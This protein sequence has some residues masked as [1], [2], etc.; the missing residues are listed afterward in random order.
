[1]DLS[2]HHFLAVRFRQIF[3]LV[4]IGLLSNTP[5]V[6]QHVDG[7]PHYDDS[8]NTGHFHIHQDST[9]HSILDLF[10]HG[11]VGGHIRNYTMATINDGVLNDY[12]TNA[13]GG[14][15]HFE[16]ADWKGLQFGVKG[17]F[18]YN[19]LGSDLTEPDTIVGQSAKWE[20]EL[21]D[22]SRPE[23]KHD[24]D[25]L[26]ELYIKYSLGRSYV[27]AG[28]ID[29]NRGPLFLRR[30]GRMKPF[31]YRGV[32]S[33]ISD[34][35]GH[36]I[37][38][39]YINGVSPRGYTEWFDLDEVIGHSS[40]GFQPNGERAHFQ[41]EAGLEAIYIAGYSNTQVKDLCAQAWNYLLTGQSYISW[42]QLDYEKKKWLLGLQYVHQS[43]M[44]HQSSLAYE[45]R[46]IQPEERANVL[47][48]KVGLIQN[49]AA[50]STEWSFSY[51]KAFDTGRFLYARELGREDF[52]VSQPRSWID[53]FGD[54]EVYML[55]MK[56]KTKLKRGEE[57]FMDTRLSRTQSP[58]VNNYEFNKYDNPSFY[59]L[60]LHPQLRFAGVLKGL[61]VGLI[62]LHKMSDKDQGLTSAQTYYK[63]NLHHFNLVTNIY[64]H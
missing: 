11:H 48:A 28:K 42:L 38:L 31:V 10:T 56:Y 62:Y 19:T 35:E 5:L 40:S 17:I 36:N 47:S 3:I 29:I 34:Y 1:M 43:A 32:W 49:R 2:P 20:A 52:Y 51:L 63:T 64:F 50:S 33:E 23:E 61:E 16:S 21:Y 25:R 57:L 24:L 30:D 4:L 39:G 59:Q 8:T 12:W 37:Q 22:V 7:I 54:L 26:E 53:G 18:S 15:I 9:I 14:S 27:T 6:A 45:Q 46:Y 13:S 58:G 44:D 41:D 55:R 60:T